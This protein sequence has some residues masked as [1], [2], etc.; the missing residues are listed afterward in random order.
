MI[1]LI[2]NVINNDVNLMQFNNASALSFLLLLFI[3]GTMIIIN[4]YDKNGA[5]GGAGLW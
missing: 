1:S 3:A 4:K 5:K 2:G